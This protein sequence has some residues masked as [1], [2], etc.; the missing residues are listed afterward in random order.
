MSWGI[1]FLTTE[2]IILKLLAPFNRLNEKHQDHELAAKKNAPPI[3]CRSTQNRFRR[4]DYLSLTVRS[5]VITFI[6]VRK[7][8]GWNADGQ[9]RCSDVIERLLEERR[10]LTNL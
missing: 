6:R 4:F 9:F 3:A 7:R 2:S 1:Q 5:A 8:N 10:S